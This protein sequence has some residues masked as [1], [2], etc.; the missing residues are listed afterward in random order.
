M[1]APFSRRSSSPG[2]RFVL[3]VF[4]LCMTLP[5]SNGSCSVRAN[6]ETV[7]L[8]AHSLAFRV[9]ERLGREPGRPPLAQYFHL[10][11][12]SRAEHCRDIAEREGAAQMVGVASRGHPADGLAAMPDGLVADRIGAVSAHGQRDQAA[13]RPPLLLAQRRVAADKVVLAEIDETA[14]PG[15]EGPV[16]RPELARPGAEALLEAQ[17]IEGP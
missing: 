2:L 8:A 14:E 4:L 1:T 12:V 10:E 3:A 16:D 5:C 9:E 13:L 11:A 15:L 17:G 7:R 6:G